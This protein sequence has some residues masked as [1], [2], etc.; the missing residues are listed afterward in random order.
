[1]IWEGFITALNGLRESKKGKR[2][3]G[4]PSHAYG[5]VSVD[6]H[7]HRLLSHS[8]SIQLLLSHSSSPPP[9][10]CWDMHSKGLCLPVVFLRSQWNGSAVAPRWIIPRTFQNTPVAQPLSAGSAPAR[11]TPGP[12]LTKVRR[13]FS[14]ANSPQRAPLDRATQALSD[15][16]VT[17]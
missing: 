11:R 1:M 10:L 14:P 7:C 8:P 17:Y 16:R 6:F 5:S 9:P 3:K 4:G 13:G 15:R 2:W 12:F